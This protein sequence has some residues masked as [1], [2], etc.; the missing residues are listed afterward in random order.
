V[1]H[2]NVLAP[3]MTLPERSSCEIW[4]RIM[5][6]IVEYTLVSLDNVFEDAPRLGFMEY[7]DEAYMRDGLGLLMSSDAMLMGRV[8]YESS[9]RIWPGRAHPWAARLNAMKKYVFSSSL[10][11]ADWNNSTLV[12][13]DAITEIKKL[14][15]AEGPNLLIWGHTR[16]AE[17]LLQ[18]HLIDQIDLSIHPIIVGHGKQFFREGQA[19]KLRLTATKCFSKIVKLTYEPQYS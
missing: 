4:R 2:A 8:S 3:Q 17:A 16:L 15:E 7:R 13:G 18:Q 6:K 11:S 1:I 5:R 9:A 14:K 12:K 10:S 19:V